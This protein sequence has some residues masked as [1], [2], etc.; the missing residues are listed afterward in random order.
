MNKIQ[1]ALLG[2]KTRSH[3]GKIEVVVGIVYNENVKHNRLCIAVELWHVLSVFW[4]GERSI[5]LK[6]TFHLTNGFLGHM[7]TI[8]FFTTRA[9]SYSELEC[10]III[11]NFFKTKCSSDQ[12]D[13]ASYFKHGTCTRNWHTV[14]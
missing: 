6:A 11:F 9:S 7:N 2:G 3:Y 5:N 1:L 10:R 14:V 4:F 12:S 13:D 8:S